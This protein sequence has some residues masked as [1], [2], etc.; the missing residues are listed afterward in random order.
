MMDN[1]INK[2]IHGDTINLLDNVSDGF[3]NLILTS[4][5]YFGARVYGNGTL[6]KEEYP[7]DY[8]NNLRNSIEPFK[9]HQATF[10]VSLIKPFILTTTEE[11]DIVFDPF[12]G[13]GTTAVACIE[14]NRNYIG[15]EI[16]K[17]Y[18]DLS[19]RRI[20]N[21]SMQLPFTG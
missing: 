4:P 8:I 18:Y 3:V 12:M 16:N 17:E 7:Q 11:K 13:S 5:P 10:P 21:V 15:F 9:I 19:I 2:I 6:G 14:L 1:Y 20:Q